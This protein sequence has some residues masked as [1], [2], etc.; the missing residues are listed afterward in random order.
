[1]SGESLLR[2][3]PHVKRVSRL[4]NPQFIKNFEKLGISPSQVI[5]EELQIEGSAFKCAGVA[6][7]GTKSK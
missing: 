4:K 5:V 2:G 6:T 3:A 1:M 7:C